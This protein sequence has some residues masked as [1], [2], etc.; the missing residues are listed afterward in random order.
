MKKFTQYLKENNQYGIL[1]IVDVQN[2]FVDF[3]PQGFVDSLI[4]YSKN[5]HSVYQIWDSND[6]N[7]PSYNFHNQKDTIVKK[8]GVK[9]SEEL[10]KTIKELNSKYPNAKEGDIFDFDDV[11]SYVIRVKNNHGWFY[12]PEKMANLFKS[13]KNKNVILVGGAYNECLKDVYEAMVAFDINVKYDKRFIYSAK[14]NNKQIY[15][16]NTQPNLI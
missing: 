10:E 1:V 6:A 13:L 15:D 7:K 4:N 9:F 2:E 5:F 16:S 8:F 12:I 3:I 14:N 11:N